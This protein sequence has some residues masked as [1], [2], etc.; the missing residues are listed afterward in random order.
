M[1]QLTSLSFEIKAKSFLWNQI[2]ILMSTLVQYSQGKLSKA[3]ILELL[4][5]PEVEPEIDDYV[6]IDGKRYMKNMAP[7]QGLYLA[8]I[9]Y[10]DRHFI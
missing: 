8:D 7:P 4:K 9:K 1:D 2:R 6:M 3:Q 5:K 10:D